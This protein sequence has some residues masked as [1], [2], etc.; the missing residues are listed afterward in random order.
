LRGDRQ[1][2][3]AGLAL[4]ENDLGESL[5]LFAVQVRFGETEIDERPGRGSIGLQGF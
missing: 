5:P 1:D 2:L 4:A 3:G